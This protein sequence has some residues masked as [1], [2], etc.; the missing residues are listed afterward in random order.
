MSFIVIEGSNGVGKTTLI[1]NMEKK[2]D[3]ISLKS[4]PD[5]YREYIPFARSLEPEIQKQM[6]M[7][8]HEAN[9]NSLN[10]ENDYILDRFFYSTIIRLNYK[11]NIPVE[12][13]V[14]EILN[15]KLNPD[16]VIYL[17][18]NKELVINRL[19][20]RENYVFDEKFFDYENTI[21]NQLSQI[22]DRMIIVGSNDQIDVTIK[23]V[24]DGLKLKKIVLKRR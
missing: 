12:D 16:I 18:A 24:T 14:K 11:L 8:W 2:Y 1:K 7:D 5:W 15:I 3:F 22:Y 9:L 20:Q 4:I 6:Y 23:K 17:Q 21:F 19:S 10:E 13:T